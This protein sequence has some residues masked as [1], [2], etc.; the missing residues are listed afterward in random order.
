[1][2][3]VYR[4][5]K[6][7]T[8]EPVAVKLLKPTIVVNVRGDT[9]ELFEVIRREEYDRFVDEYIASSSLEHLNIVKALDSGNH[10]GRPFIVF[11]YV[12]GPSAE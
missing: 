3:V 5:E 4:A 12:A 7:G 8:E 9:M 10:D 2:A 11:E 1:M 6:M